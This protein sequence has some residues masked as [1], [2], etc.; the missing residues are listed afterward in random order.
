MMKRWYAQNMQVPQT[1]VL[2]IYSLQVWA[3]QTQGFF[4]KSISHNVFPKGRK[5]IV[6]FNYIITLSRA[7][8]TEQNLHF[9]VDSDKNLVL[10]FGM[11]LVIK[12]F[13]VAS[14]WLIHFKP[15]L[16]SM[17][18]L[19]PWREPQD[20]STLNTTSA[21]SLQAMSLVKWTQ[22]EECLAETCS[23]TYLC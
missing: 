22:Q 17:E 3:L 16:S 14:F 13:S 15:S 6:C 19:F 4:I 11:H 2:A 10:H 1:D 8:M 21:L 7:V 5:W 20:T 18:P 23:K 12:H 9:S